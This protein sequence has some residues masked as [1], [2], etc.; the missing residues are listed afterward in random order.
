MPSGGSWGCRRACFI[1]SGTPW[2]YS[3]SLG[4]RHVAVDEVEAGGGELGLEPAQPPQV[5]AQRHEAE[6]GLVAEDGHRHDLVAVGL[7]RLHRLGDG[8]GFGQ[9][10]DAEEQVEDG[11]A[12]LRGG[13]GRYGGFGVHADQ[14]TRTRSD[15]P[16]H[17]ASV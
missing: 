14:A 7:G 6:V 3:E 2:A 15:R 16:G 5:G 17:E 4:E 1:S 13:R 9:R 12:D 10:A 8:L 11:F